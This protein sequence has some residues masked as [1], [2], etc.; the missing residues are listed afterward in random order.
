MTRQHPL[1]GLGAE[2]L[3]RQTLEPLLHV[4][5]PGVTDAEIQIANVVSQMLDT[6]SVE[7]TVAVFSLLTRP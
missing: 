3:S 5:A 4:T 2:G 7:F 1:Q 6:D